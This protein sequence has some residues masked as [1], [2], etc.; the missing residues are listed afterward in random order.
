MINTVALWML[1]IMA[2]ILLAG[3]VYLLGY[4]RGYD[5]ALHD[6]R[7]LHGKAA[8]EFDRMIA[9]PVPISREE[10]ERA[11]KVYEDMKRNSG[12]NF[13]L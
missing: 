6:H 9:N 4:W 2:L 10:Y 13:Y 3:L 8:R 7:I 12:G 1:L 11:R 5:R